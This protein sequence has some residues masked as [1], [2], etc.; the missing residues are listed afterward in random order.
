[1]KKIILAILIFF[2]LTAPA[3]AG[4]NVLLHICNKFMRAYIPDGIGPN[5]PIVIAIHPGASNAIKWEGTL[6][7]DPYA[8][9]NKF[10]IVYPNGYENPPL[11]NAEAWNA[12]WCCG[13]A[14]TTQSNDSGFMKQVIN[15]MA[16]NFSIDKSKVYMAGYSNGAMLAFR[17]VCENPTD[18]QG[19]VVMA[20]ALTLNHPFCKS[21]INIPIIW[22][23][24]DADL[25]IPPAGGIGINGNYFPSVADTKSFM[26]SKGVTFTM[27]EMP[28]VTH[29]YNSISAGLLA[30]FG[31]SQAQ[32]IADMVGVTTPP[33]K[34]YYSDA[35]ALHPYF[36]DPGNT[37]PYQYGP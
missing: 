37:E 32:L 18:I 26:E 13:P 11:F 35:A 8:D 15:Y 33:A 23:Y 24:G 9:T 12:G 29:A 16:E 22:G 20:S 1:M 31:T 25:N 30:D 28:G 10:I 21:G 34:T 36:S 17:Y 7:L 27:L 6:G 2:L 14:F 3:L 19:I 5:P 4:T